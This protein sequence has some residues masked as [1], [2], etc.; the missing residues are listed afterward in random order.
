MLYFVEINT[1]ETVEFKIS[2]KMISACPT[3]F[4]VIITIFFLSFGLQMF[5]RP[6]RSVEHIINNVKFHGMQI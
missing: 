2:G 5:K 3:L 4:P 1:N 6:V